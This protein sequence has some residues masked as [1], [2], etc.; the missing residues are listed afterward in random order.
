M[1]DLQQNNKIDL[2]IEGLLYALLAF[3]PL[4]FG[5]VQ[6]WSQEV[7]I[8]LSAVITVCFAAKLVSNRRFRLVWTWAYLPAAVFILIVVFQL[9][10]LSVGFVDA[11]SPNTSG[12]KTELFSYLPNSDTLLDSMPLSFYPHATM[13]QLR[14]LLALASIL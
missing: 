6:A 12:L 3:M 11:I 9:I 7:V 13:T 2:T 4:A 8:I 10:P 14:L 5:S 1:N